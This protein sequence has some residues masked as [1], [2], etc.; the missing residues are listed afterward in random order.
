MATA[1]HFSLRRRFA[2]HLT[3][4]CVL[5]VAALLFVLY[6]VS[7]RQEMAFVDRILDERMRALVQ[8]I[9]AGGFPP[10]PRSQSTGGYIVRAPADRERLPVHLR[11][12]L[13]G[14]HAVWAGD[15][16][17]YVFVRESGE[18]LLYVTYDGGNRKHHLATFGWILLVGLAAVAAAAAALSP[19]WASVLIRQVADLAQRVDTLRAGARDMTVA[20]NLDEEV[21][22]LAAAF[23]HYQSSLMRTVERER[24][25]SSNVAHELRTP[26]TL[27]CT[28]CE[29]LMEDPGLTQRTRRHV[30]RIANATDHMIDSIKSFL[31][32]AREGDLGGDERVPIKECVL[33]MLEPF[34]ASLNAKGVRVHVEVAEYAA[35]HAN[36]EAFFIVAGNL[37]K[38]AVKYTDAGFIAVRYLGNKLFVEDTG[39]GIPANDIP[40]IFLR[41]YRARAASE[42]GREGLGLGLAIVKR[43]CDHYGWT[44][45]VQSQL[46]EGTTVS[47]EFVRPGHLF[48]A[49]G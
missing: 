24:E 36:R 3:A 31:V 2:L 13:Q 16:L 20:A 40:N 41:F 7:H 29:L 45:A 37:I 5:F 15:G 46:G 1:L 44:L 35:I 28:S 43:I 9:A 48:E 10:A 22:R 14:K 12:L 33:E 38:N 26:L 19:W 47:V 8:E 42:S 34:G 17:E 21:A 18:G 4:F 25:F 30:A 6:L 39:C 32:L 11:T 49:A 23:D 27:I